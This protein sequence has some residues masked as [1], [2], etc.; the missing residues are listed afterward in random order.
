MIWSYIKVFITVEIMAFIY[1]CSDDTIINTD[2]INE[3]AVP[4][5]Y[6]AVSIAWRVR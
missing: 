5:Q 3:D 6:T 1:N 4:T 2:N